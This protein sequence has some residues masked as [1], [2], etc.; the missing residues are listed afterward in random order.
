MKHLSAFSLLALAL[1]SVSAGTCDSVR[2][3]GDVEVSRRASST[4][5]KEQQ[6]YWSTSSGDLKPSCILFPE[7]TQELADIVAIIRDNNETFAVK[8][9]G[10]SPNDHF[11]SVDGGPLISTARLNQVTLNAAEGKVRVGP[12]NRWENVADALD[13]T[14]WNAV[15]GRIGNVGVG[16]L[17]LGGGLSFLSTQRGWAANSVLEYE[18]V[19]PNATVVNVTQSNYPDLFLALRGG[20]N[21]FGVV[22]SFLLQAYPQGEIWGGSMFFPSTPKTDTVILNAIRDFTEHYPDE[23]AAIIPTAILTGAGLVNMWTIFMFY[24]GPEPPAGTFANF[25]A[26]KPFLNTCKTRSFRDFVRAN[27]YGVITGSVYHI[28]TETM[29]LPSA[30]NIDVLEDIHE[31]WR[32]VRNSVKLVPGMTSNIGYQPLPKG[33]A[34]IA[35]QRGGDLLDMSDDVDRIVLQ[36][37]LSHLSS[38]NTPQIEA[39]MRTAY[40]G[41]KDRVDN[42]TA[43]GVLPETHLPL[44]MNDAF[45]DQDYFGRLRPE[46]QQLV[47]RVQ[48]EVDPDGMFR[49]RTGGFKI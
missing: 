47:A 20:G 25:T 17:L 33:M 22:A 26:A 10:H 39:A 7:S 9:G 1:R 6:E 42:Y 13:G 19:L 5:F 27:N 38:I 49:D 48:Q 34:R 8:S 43:E 35:K 23:K 30:A 11:A 24:N 31:H 29:P 37:T 40:T 36:I 3:L 15:G 16:G 2:A 14:G 4:Y 18:L 46:H 12:G 32:N 21:N 28:G 45:Y 41:F 44:F